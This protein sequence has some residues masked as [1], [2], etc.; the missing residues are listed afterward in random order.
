MS[1]RIYLGTQIEQTLATAVLT[2]S[3]RRRTSHTVQIQPL[4]EAVAAANIDIPIPEDPALRPRTPFTFQRFAI[5]ALCQYQ[6]KALYL[7]SDMLV[8]KDISELWEQPFRKTANGKTADSKTADG[9]TADAKAA[10]PTADLLSVP[11]PPESG[12]SPQYSV[13]LLN[14]AQL[15][16]NVAQLVQSLTRGRWTYREFVLDM[17]PAAIKRADLPAGWNDLE[18]YNPERTALLHYTDMPS[19]PWLSTDNPLA[20]L[21]CNELIKAVSA[22]EIARAQVCDS[23]E[24]GWVRPSLLTQID[25]G[26]ADPQQL[27]AEVLRRDR[28]AFVPPHIWQKYLQH[29]VLQQPKVRQWFSYSYAALKTMANPKALAGRSR[30]S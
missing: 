29:P 27:P 25:S 15:D 22:G 14:C 18:R 5:P 10:E 12:R 1:I 21:W 24:R 11:E 2:Y 20:A 9:K 26:I 16:W 6:G 13:M 28:T 17:A 19:Q 4:Y 30:H 3:I 7:D 23:I 8:F